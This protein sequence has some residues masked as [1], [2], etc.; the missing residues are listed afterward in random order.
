MLHRLKIAIPL[1]LIS[2]A[3][4]RLEA[5]QGESIYIKALAGGAYTSVS[6]TAE[7][8]KLSFSAVSGLG[9]LYVGGSLNKSFKVFGFTG[10]A[11]APKPSAKTT[12]LNIETVYSMQT[13]FD[14]GLGAAYYLKGGQ[15][16]SLGASIAQ[17]HYRYSVYDSSVSTYTRHGWGSHL[18]AGQEFAVSPR[19]SLGVSA[20]VYYGQVAD[21]GP[22]PF[23]N[24]TISNF[25]AGVVFSVTYD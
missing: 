7:D 11:L 6:E 14:L 10:L 18:L 12:N 8:M 21:T 3:A 4:P 25:Y 16:L 9:Y 13:I 20:I 15:Y 23:N 17:S 2:L 19:L 24:S 5:L 1:T 22:A